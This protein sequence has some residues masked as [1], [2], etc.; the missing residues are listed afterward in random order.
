VI[1]KKSVGIAGTIGGSSFEHKSEIEKIEEIKEQNKILLEKLYRVIELIE[2]GLNEIKND[3]YYEIITMMYFDK[4]TYE[5]IAEKLNL[6][7]KTV[8]RHR[9]RLVNELSL[10]IFPDEILEKF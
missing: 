4:M 6:S 7:D 1:L 5:Q 10:I 9:N 8:K 3:K 2:F